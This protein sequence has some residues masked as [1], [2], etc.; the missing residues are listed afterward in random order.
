MKSIQSNAYGKENTT[1]LEIKNI[2]NEIKEEIINNYNFITY[3]INDGINE[4]NKYTIGINIDFNNENDANN[5]Y[6]YI[7][8][9]YKEYSNLLEYARIR[10]YSSEIDKLPELGNVWTL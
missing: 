4:N 5:L 3:G 6:N 2:K 9:K 1:N 8:Q 7:K 10:I